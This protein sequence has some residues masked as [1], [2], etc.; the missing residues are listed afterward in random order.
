MSFL[1]EIGKKK[2]ILNSS[3]SPKDQMPKA[4]LSKKNN[5]GD[6]T[7]PDFK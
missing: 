7:I 3:G 1:T 6:I 4:I 5:V 2:S